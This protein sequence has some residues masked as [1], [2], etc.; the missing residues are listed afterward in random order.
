MIKILLHRL[1]VAV[2]IEKGNVL[3][4]CG[5]PLRLMNEIWDNTFNFDYQEE[6][7]GKEFEINGINVNEDKSVMPEIV[8]LDTVNTFFMG[9]ID[10]R[11]YV[12]L[13]KRKMPGIFNTYAVAAV[14]EACIQIVSAKDD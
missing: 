4:S 9:H 13:D 1:A 7:P 3:L 6:N 14:K 11:K 5:C 2:A 10:T 8:I 12:E